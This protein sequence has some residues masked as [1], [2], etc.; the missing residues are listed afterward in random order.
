M[1][2]KRKT[3]SVAIRLACGSAVAAGLALTGVAGAKEEEAV[4]LEKEQVTGSHIKQVDIETAQPLIVID[5]ED[6]QNRGFVTVQDVLDS[7]TQNTSGSLTQQSIHGF[8]PAASGFDLR[9][10][11][12][13]RVLT[14]IDGKRV[15][16]YPLAAGAEI[17]FVDT[18]N[19]P[20]GAIERI[21]ILAGG[22]SAIY[23]SDAMGGVVN[24]IMRKDYDGASATIYES[25]TDDGGRD[26][27]RQSGIFGT[28]G[29]W[30]N[31]TLFLEHE[32]REQLKATDRK[33]FDIGTDLAFDNPFSSYSSYGISL[34]NSGGTVVNT[35]SPGEC[36]SRGL[37]FW[38]FGN[39]IAGGV[40]GFDR[41]SMRDLLPEQE[42][43]SFLGNFSYNINNDHQLYGRVDYTQADVTTR[44]E[45]MPVNDYDYIVEGGKVTLQGLNGA[46]EIV[47]SVTFD[48]ATAFGGDFA[49]LSDGVYN[50]TRRMLEFGHR[51]NDADI[52]NKGI[53]L[54]LRGT[55]TEMFD[56]DFTYNWSD[57]EVYSKQNGYATVQGY[58]D[59]LASGVAGRSQFDLMT[60]EEVKAASYSPWSKGVSSFTGYSFGV[61]G[62]VYELPAGTL[63]IAAGV[64]YFE[65]DFKGTSDEASRNFEI[66]ATGGGNQGSGD[67]NS[68]GIY[69]EAMVPVIDELVV[70][71]ALRFDDYSDMGS[72]TSPQIGIEY[73][74][75]ETLLLRG[76]YSDTFRAPD[77]IRMYGE[78]TLGFSQITDPKGCMDAGGTIDPNSPIDACN[79]E[80]YVNVFGGAN[81]DLEPETGSNWNIGAVYEYDALNVSLDYWEVKVE[82]IVST[83]GAQDIA[84]DYDIYGHLITRDPVTG[85]IK[86]IDERPQNL[87][88]RK[89]KGIDLAVGYG[90][91]L[92]TYGELKFDLSLTYLMEYET[93]KK[94][95]DSF[96]DEIEES[97]VPKL[98]AN[99][100]TTWAWN[101]FSTTLFIEHIGKMNG[102]NKSDMIEWGY[103]DYLDEFYSLEIDPYTT[104]NLT[105]KYDINDMFTVRG[106]VNNITNEGPNPDWTNYQ[107]PHYPREYYSPVGREYF[108]SFDLNF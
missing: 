96:E 24:I 12:L 46:G 28:T 9:G 78:Q 22:S 58:F 36:A 68:T 80:L 88:V 42:R 62:D 23:G 77:M 94:P 43:T 79:G 27:H 14:L 26:V 41:T 2:N 101:D 49:G 56:Y 50:Y 13:G 83:L 81:P 71:P 11:G 85:Y 104:A 84:S 16:K 19:I 66:L 53:L 100:A 17:N 60:P 65:E 44:I 72:H 90:F 51:T 15:S 70:K 105:A 75:I 38:D 93:Q 99:L 95:S 102:V 4:K 87:S 91:D 63:S 3:L 8:T 31:V 92:K 64:E 35:I 7:V 61:T 69:L 5:Q 103:G 18:A 20:I 106:G 67:R 29:N 32:K 108:L 37:Q 33:G 98:R 6:I 86:S 55:L 59:Y 45:P 74:P 30:G 34:R 40:C 25:V 107:W 21:E 82:D 57:Q 10:A 97:N 73:R 1:F 39:S 76:N 54:G 89:T 48:Q 52:T 47:D